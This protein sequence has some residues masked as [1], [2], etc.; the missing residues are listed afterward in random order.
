[1][2]LVHSLASVDR[3]EQVLGVVLFLVACQFCLLVFVYW[4][5]CTVRWV[6]FHGSSS[7]HTFHPIP[8]LF[9]S[10]RRVWQTPLGVMDHHSPA[11]SA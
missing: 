9:A 3:L 5:V 1:M 7:G 4:D 11:R 6:L 2:A 10:L 8:S